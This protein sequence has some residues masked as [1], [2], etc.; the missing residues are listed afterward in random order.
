MVEKCEMR[1]AQVD[2]LLEYDEAPLSLESVCD[3]LR[4]IHLYRTAT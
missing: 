2:Q 3:W 1:V 4:Q